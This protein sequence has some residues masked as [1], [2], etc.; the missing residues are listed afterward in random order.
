MMQGVE[1]VVIW[2]VQISEIYVVR[3]LFVLVG[4]VFVSGV[5]S[6]YVCGVLGI[7]LFWIVY[8]EFNCVVICECCWFV[9]DW[10]GDYEYVVIMEIDQ[11]FFWI[12]DFGFVV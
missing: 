1:F 9:I 4:W 5:V 12:G 7:G 2:V 3:W 10:F 11:V 6:G 8:G